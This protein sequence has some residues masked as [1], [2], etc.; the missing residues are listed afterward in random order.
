MEW[1]KVESSNFV[2]TWAM[3]SVS[4]VMT[5]TWVRSGSRDTFLNFRAVVI[6]GMGEAKHF[7]FGVQIDRGEY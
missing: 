3:S 5:N 4:L 1:W 6:F 7:I 2:Y